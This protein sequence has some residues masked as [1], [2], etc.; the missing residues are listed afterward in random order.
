MIAILTGTRPEI[1]KIAPVL[2]E[3]RK[4]N[5][6]H[7]FIHS[8]Q[9]YSKEMDAT[10]IKDLNLPTPDYNFGVGSGSHAVQTGKIMEH[11]ETL[12]NEVKPQ[13]L[14]V[15][16]DTNTTLAGA[17]AAKKVH[18]PVAHIEAGLRSFDY[19]MPEEINRT[20]VDRIS[21]VLL[22]P[23]KQAKANLKKEGI[24]GKKVV[25]TGNTVVDALRQHVA[26]TKKS[27]ILNKN[28][29]EEN[30]YIL[31][32]AHRAENVDTKPALEKLVA[33]LNHAQNK[34][35]LPIYWPL[36][37]RTKQRLEEFNI[38]LSKKI[39]TSKPIGYIDMLTV[40]N[41]ANVVLTDSG[42][43]Q[44]EAF[45]LKKPLITLRD[46]TERPETLTANFVVHTSKKK[47]DEALKA[48]GDE[49]VEWT[50]ALGDGL[51]STRIVDALLK[52]IT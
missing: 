42:G 47:F 27:N 15:H 1:I 45:I 36:H 7:I 5:I 12:C 17:L 40:L 44:E 50:D 41:N 37:P 43:I 14:V 20:I 13:I 38:K 10:I 22:A 24:T 39:T 16:G 46:S 33:L 31:V 2:R 18:T 8:N 4:R 34:T 6:P 52:F 28:N 23:T 29:L 49:A 9:H 30:K 26:L 48:Y 11:V 51:A 25:V 3:L 35:N 19:R 21:D 32:T